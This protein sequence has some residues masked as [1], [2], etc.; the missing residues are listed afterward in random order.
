MRVGVWTVVEPHE[1]PEMLV[2]HER[3]VLVS[4]VNI[5]PAK[6]PISVDCAK[7]KVESRTARGRASRNFFNFK[8]ASQRGG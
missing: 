4:E 7:V 6:T 8:M 1:G 3:G 2:M 5:P